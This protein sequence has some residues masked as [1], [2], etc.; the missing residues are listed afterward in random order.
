MDDKLTEIVLD[1]ISVF[2][3][4]IFSLVKKQCHVNGPIGLNIT[5]DLFLPLHLVIVYYRL[6]DVK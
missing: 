3:S 6:M 2:F 1:P 5:F 4:L